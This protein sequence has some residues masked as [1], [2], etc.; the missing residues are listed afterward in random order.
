M[1]P[2]PNWGHHNLVASRIQF[3]PAN[4]VGPKKGRYTPSEEEEEEDEMV[5]LVHNFGARK[6]KRGASI[7]RATDAIPEVVG[8]ADQDPTDGGSEEQAIIVMDSSKMGF[9]CQSASKSIPTENSGEVP[10]THEEAREGIPS[11]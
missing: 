5:D 7:K 3:G 11:G 6:R 9:H 2:S 10:R 1:T 8:E 4:Q